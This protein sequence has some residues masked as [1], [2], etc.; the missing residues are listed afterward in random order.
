VTTPDQP[1]LIDHH[2]DIT[3]IT[4]NRPNSLNSLTP[5]MV[6]RLTD[7]LGEVDEE[8][9]T[10]AVVITGAGSGFCGGGDVRSFGSVPDQRVRRR[11][12]HLVQALLD[13]EKPL[14]ARVNG[15]AA[16]LGLVIAL[17]ADISIVVDNAKLGDPHVKLGLV[18]GDGLTVIL[19]LLVGPNRA[20]ELL[21]TSRYLSGREAEAIG[22][23]NCA[24]PREELD[25]T[26]AA[27]ARELADQPP[28]AVRATKAAV[29]RYLKARAHDVLELSLAYE[30]ISRSLPD[31]HDRVARWRVDHSTVEPSPS[32]A[33]GPHAR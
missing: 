4:L 18:A 20:K 31:Y 12:W 23:V 15:S 7:V 29:N 32:T 22:M 25:V 5:A 3:T 11:G 19:P 14:I 10:N 27:V 16:G 21:L 8:P 13:I 24:V 26:V 30:E 33:G 1:I 17:L 6:M 9:S 2:G 28:Y